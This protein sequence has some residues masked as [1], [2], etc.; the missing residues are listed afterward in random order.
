MIQLSL[1]LIREIHVLIVT[2]P[3][4][5]LLRVGQVLHQGLF[6]FQMQGRHVLDM[7]QGPGLLHDGPG[8]FQRIHERLS[9]ARVG[10]LGLLNLDVTLDLN[11]INL[12]H[13]L[14]CHAA[15]VQGDIRGFAVKHHG[16][17][18]YK[19][20]SVQR[21]CPGQFGLLGQVC[22]RH[23]HTL[24]R[25]VLHFI[26]QGHTGQSHV[27]TD[28]ECHGHGYGRDQRQI[29]FRDQQLNVRLLVLLDLQFHIERRLHGLPQFIDRRERE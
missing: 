15:G 23:L 8:V 14:L 22:H 18:L 11:K 26:A 4:N 13:S 28:S 25:T 17:T 2:I 29:S 1:V 16:V 12:A 10:L 21:Q 6:G 27:I 3:F 19:M 9:K 24:C 7:T 20:P 5:H